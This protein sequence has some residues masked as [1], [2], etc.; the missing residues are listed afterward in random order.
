MMFVRTFPIA[1]FTLSLLLVSAGRWNVPWFY[2]YTGLVWGSAGLIN[3]MAPRELVRER[4]KPPSDRD[5]Q[6]RR[7]ALP[8]MIGHYVLAG[9]GVRFGWTPV[10]LAVR[11][12]GLA[13]VAAGMGFVG[14]TLLENPFAS[15][16]VRVQEDRGHRVITSGPYAL[17]R[18]PM[19]FGVVLFSLGSGPA[20]GSWWSALPILAIL[21]VFVRRTLLEDRMLRDELPGYQAYAQKV[22]WRVIPG[23]F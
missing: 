16:A 4:M 8:L 17:V 19:Y 20:L 5:A 23:V 1:V 9:L 11:V 14:W 21:P 13:L 6:S 12:T 22:R 7:I 3:T 10:P 18:H 15:S 2:F